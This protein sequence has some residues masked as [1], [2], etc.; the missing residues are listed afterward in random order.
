[1]EKW[2]SKTQKFTEFYQISEYKQPFWAYPLRD[3]YEICS[4]CSLFQ[5][6]TAVKIWMESLE[7][8]RVMG[9]LV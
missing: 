6:V 2:T 9:A 7:G 5:D 3:L 4:V 8:Y 1:M